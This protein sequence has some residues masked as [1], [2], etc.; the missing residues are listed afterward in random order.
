MSL[1]CRLGDQPRKITSAKSATSGGKRSPT[2]G[3]ACH[4]VCVSTKYIV[5]MKVNI[6][7]FTLQ[8]W[9]PIMTKKCYMKTLSFSHVDN[10]TILF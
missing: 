9:S 8:P 6:F 5:Y 2:G 3:S 7:M 4:N 1:V 10:L